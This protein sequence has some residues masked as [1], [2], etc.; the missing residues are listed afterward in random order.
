MVVDRIQRAFRERRAVHEHHRI[1]P[2]DD[3]RLRRHAQTQTRAIPG[4]GGGIDPCC[5]EVSARSAAQP[6]IVRMP[7]AIVARLRSL[8]I[9]LLPCMGLLVS[10]AFCI[11]GSLAQLLVRELLLMGVRVELA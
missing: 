1:G 5:Q 4:A 6:A 7:K 11:A 2:G 8:G 9:V 3:A 10:R